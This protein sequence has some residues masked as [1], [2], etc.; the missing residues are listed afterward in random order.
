MLLSVAT[1]FTGRP[2]NY[3]QKLAEEALTF[4][5]PLEPN[6]STVSLVQFAANLSKFGQT[7]GRSRA[8][9]YSA[10]RLVHVSYE[11]AVLCIR[12]SGRPSTEKEHL[13]KRVAQHN[14]A[15]SLRLG[16]EKFPCEIR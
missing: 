13:A 12:P 15:K 11:A 2:N 10:W 16:W 5:R 14:P 6:G 7:V 4:N 8:W 9:K 3:L 1:Y